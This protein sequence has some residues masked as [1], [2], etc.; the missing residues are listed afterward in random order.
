MIIKNI[1]NPKRSSVK[2]N[3]LQQEMLP[4]VRKKA[5]K[6]FLLPRVSAMDDNK[7]EVIATIRKAMDNA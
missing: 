3:K 1:P 5:M 4:S 7:G 6:D 2:K